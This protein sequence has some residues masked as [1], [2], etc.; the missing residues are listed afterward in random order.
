M[1][2]ILRGT[3][4]QNPTDQKILENIFNMQM[5]NY[6]SKTITCIRKY[7][8]KKERTFSR[9]LICAFLFN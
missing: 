3:H 6:N 9:K 1:K 7:R 8:G 5:Q 4:S 2:K